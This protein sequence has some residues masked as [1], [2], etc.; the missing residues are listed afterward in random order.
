MSLTCRNKKSSHTEIF[1]YE[2]SK[3]DDDKRSGTIGKKT[4][5]TSIEE[6]TRANKA[7]NRK[8][9]TNERESETEKTQSCIVC[10]C[11]CVLLLL[12][13]RR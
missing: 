10:V 4:C 13:T 6:M 8:R 7:V 12:T 2:S 11:M 1:Q 5:S 9:K 3:I